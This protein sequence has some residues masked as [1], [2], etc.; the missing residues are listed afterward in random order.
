M[1][2]QRP[3]KVAQRVL[4][5]YKGSQLALLLSLAALLALQSSKTKD[6]GHAPIAGGIFRTS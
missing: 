5:Y 6:F 1:P 3:T 2:F 4:K